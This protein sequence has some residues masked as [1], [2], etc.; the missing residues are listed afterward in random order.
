MRHVPDYMWHEPLWHDPLQRVTSV[1]TLCRLR[2][3]YVVGFGA[4]LDAVG[5]CCLHS[6]LVFLWVASPVL[7]GHFLVAAVGIALIAPQSVNPKIKLEKVL[8]TR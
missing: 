3:S 5:L 7:E 4:F 2:D 8:T 1:R 6:S